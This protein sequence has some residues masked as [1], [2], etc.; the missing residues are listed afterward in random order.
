MILLLAAFSVSSLRQQI[1]Q[2]DLIAPNKYIFGD[3]AYVNTHY[4]VTPFKAPS[5]DENSFSN[6]CQE[7][8]QC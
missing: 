8:L 3:N 2:Q 6:L 7:I 5:E 4:I 1:E